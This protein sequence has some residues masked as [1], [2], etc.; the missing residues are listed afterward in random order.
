LEALL[1]LPVLFEASHH[2][3][4]LQRVALVGEIH[5]QLQI[6]LDDEALDAQGTSHPLANKK[7]YVLNNIVGDLV[8]W[9]KQSWMA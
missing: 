6:P 3:L 9:L 7:T 5:D 8:L 2:V 1:H 4:A